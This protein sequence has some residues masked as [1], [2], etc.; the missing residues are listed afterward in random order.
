MTETDTIK[1]TAESNHDS[2]G[3]TS[4][5]CTVPVDTTLDELMDS[6]RQ[7]VLS[8]GYMEGSWN[9]VI[10]SRAEELNH[11]E[12]GVPVKN[13]YEVPV[14][15]QIDAEDAMMAREKMWDILLEIEKMVEYHRPAD[16]IPDYSIGDATQLELF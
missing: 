7:M 6:I 8:L 14:T 4:F 5:T 10:K 1:I 2:F 12:P 13:T 9:N 16:P 11:T 15:F 3:K